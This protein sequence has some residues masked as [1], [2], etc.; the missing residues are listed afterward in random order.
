MG[1]FGTQILSVSWRDAGSLLRACIDVPLERLPRDCQ[2]RII[3]SSETQTCWRIFRLKFREIPVAFDGDSDALAE[4]PT[5]A[6]I[7]NSYHVAF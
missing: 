1:D 2:V 7:S 4:I 6:W 3:L 5:E